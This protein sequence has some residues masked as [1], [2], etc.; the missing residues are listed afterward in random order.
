MVSAGAEFEPVFM[1]EEEKVSD[2][3]VNEQSHFK[4][5]SMLNNKSSF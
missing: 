4:I 3:T 2:A 1:G 5:N